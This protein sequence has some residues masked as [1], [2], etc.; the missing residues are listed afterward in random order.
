MTAVATSAGANKVGDPAA[1]TDGYSAA[2]AGAAA[3]ASGRRRRG[4]G[5]RW[6]PL[7]G[8]RRPR[9]RRRADARQLIEPVEHGVHL[10]PPDTQ[11]GGA[12]MN[13]IL[14]PSTSSA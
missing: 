9:N 10:Q 4:G 14:R 11:K 6:P 8:R 5:V 3:I 1:L 2:F 12:T 7:G 13:I